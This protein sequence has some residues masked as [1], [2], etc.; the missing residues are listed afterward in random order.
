[1]AEI[2]RSDQVWINALKMPEPFTVEQIVQ[3]VDA[4]ERTVRK[5]LNVMADRGFLSRKGG[6][7]PEKTKFARVETIPAMEEAWEDE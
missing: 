6:R 7:G 1:M 2:S 4:G 3:Q 5:R